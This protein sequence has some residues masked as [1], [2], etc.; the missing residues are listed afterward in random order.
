[1]RPIALIA[2]IVTAL[3]AV[4]G[5]T[6]GSIICPNSGCKI[7]ET[8]TTIR[9]LYL[10]LMGLLFFQAVFWIL[11]V[12][13]GKAKSRMD[14]LGVLLISGLVF[15]SALL[16]YQVFVARTFCGYCLLIFGFV[17]ALNL[18]YGK[19]QM[20]AGVAVLAAAIF[21]FSILTFVPT[22]VLSQ[23]EPLKSAAYG[24]KS[25]SAPSKEIYLIFSSNC[26]YC[27]NVL[28]TLSN[29]NSCD[30]YLNPI[31][32]VDAI[33][34]IE[35]APNPK[36]SPAV[37]RLVLAALGIDSVPVL[38]VKSAEGFRLIKGERQI[39]NYVRH[40]CFTEAD[41]MYFEKNVVSGR[42]EI[43]VLTE[44][45]GECSLAIDCNQQVK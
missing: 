33:K 26:P 9:P 40:A 7:V 27:E 19:R 30:L 39:V 43:T 6:Y 37:N 1:M 28:E 11:H 20:V 25:C 45:E 29:C 16:A 38:V 35:L 44:Q 18:L 41:V 42:D 5:L 3:Q 13:K 23:A 34:N 31:D 36:F 24:V 10:N 8:L 17:L 14:L 12:S 15:E 4:F 32:K 2:S 21:S 22:A